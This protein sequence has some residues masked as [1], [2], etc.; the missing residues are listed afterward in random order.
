MPGPYFTSINIDGNTKLNGA[1]SP[2][3]SC[4]L[5]LQSQGVW[6]QIFP[7]GDG[8]LLTIS[9]CNVV[10]DFDAQISVFS[11]SCTSLQCEPVDNT[12]CTLPAPINTGEIVSFTPAPDSSYY[13]VVHGAGDESGYYQIKIS[14]ESADY[15]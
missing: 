11:G 8:G 5:N 3:A 6:Y 15:Q 2:I 4:G 10:T 9:A 13:V 1:G 7:S 12:L 14:E